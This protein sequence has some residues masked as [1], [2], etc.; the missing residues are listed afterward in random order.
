[1]CHLS[2]QKSNNAANKHDDLEVTPE[3]YTDKQANTIQAQYHI[4]LE[5]VQ[6]AEEACLDLEYHHGIETQ[7]TPDSAKYQS[8]MTLLASQNYHFALDEFER[9]IV[10]QLFELTKLN[11]SGVGYKQCEKITKALKAQV[12]AICKVLEA[13]NMAAKAVFPP[14]KN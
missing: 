9:L 8:T 11:M 3:K 5:E 13:Y 14:Q 7:W 12:E 1:M 4:T 10:Q 2:R 6:I